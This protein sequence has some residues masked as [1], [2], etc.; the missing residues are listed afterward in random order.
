MY[1]D[2]IG[3]AAGAILAICFVPQIIQTLKTR[4]ADDVSL[5]MMLLTLLSAVLYEVY[6]AV[7]GLWPVVIM[8]GIFGA[9]VTF[10]IGLKIYFSREPS[11]ATERA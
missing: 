10:Q 7:L 5:G 1:V 4:R 3:Y 8:N 6:A 11:V 2:L 9:L